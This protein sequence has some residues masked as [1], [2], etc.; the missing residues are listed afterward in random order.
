M[1]GEEEGERKLS[2][3]KVRGRLSTGARPQQISEFYHG[4]V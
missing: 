4:P 3:M 1:S 2:G